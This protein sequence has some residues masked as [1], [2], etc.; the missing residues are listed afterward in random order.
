MIDKNIKLGKNNSDFNL[1]YVSGLIDS[2]GHISIDKSYIMIVNTKKNVLDTCS[3][4]LKGM[5]INS[6]I[7]KRKPSKMDKLDSYRMYISNKFINLNH[8]SIKI[9]RYSRQRDGN[10]Q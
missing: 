5:G 3:I 6:S 1:G 7:N 8:A 4:S 9:D 10:T 2:E